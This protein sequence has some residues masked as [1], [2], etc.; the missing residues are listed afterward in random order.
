MHVFFRN[1]FIFSLIVSMCFG[2]PMDVI[3]GLYKLKKKK[4]TY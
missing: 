4:R 1:P 2:P 3:W